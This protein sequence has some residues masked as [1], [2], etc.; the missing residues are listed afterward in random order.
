VS[1]ALALAQSVADQPGGL[2]AVVDCARF[3]DAPALFA[4]MGLRTL[5]LFLDRP[6][7]AS[8]PANPL[9]IP[10]DRVELNLL[11]AAPR[12]ETACVLWN[13]PP[14]ELLVLHHF[15]TLNR[16][17]I[18]AQEPAAPGGG[19]TEMVLFRHWDPSVLALLSPLLDAGQR[20]RLFGPLHQMTLFSADA[21]RVLQASVQHDGGPADRGSL[22][23]S[24][25]QMTQIT[26]AMRTRSHRQIARYLR[27][28]AQAQTAA[29]SD[30]A[31][32]DHVA[33]AE[34]VAKTWGVRTE[35]GFGR[36]AWL[37]L[38]TQGGL[39]QM[40]EARSYITGDG[41]PS[42]GRVRQV[43]SAIAAQLSSG[44]AQT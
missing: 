43:M 2:F 10:L 34:A 41:S 17:R 22:A 28:T 32:L 35:A 24:S 23:L 20:A 27:E 15:R 8:A 12:I 1:P 40:P 11:A 9:M 29:M 7:R 4:R 18:P 37:M 3:D 14:D 33:G 13:G 26:A 39:V 19:A 21:G 30:P 5:P 44:W 16:V 36:F 25:D 31:L 42:D 6:N 38:A